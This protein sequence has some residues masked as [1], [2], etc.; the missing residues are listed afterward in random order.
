MIK[1]LTLLFCSLAFITSSTFPE[2]W[3]RSTFPNVWVKVDQDKK[4]EVIRVSCDGSMASMVVKGDTLFRKI[5]QVSTHLIRS[6]ERR[7][8]DHYVIHAYGLVADSVVIYGVSAV[9]YE[10]TV[11]DRERKL[12]RWD[13]IVLEEKDTTTWLMTPAAYSPEFR[14]AKQ[15]CKPKKG[16]FTLGF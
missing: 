12:V 4:G 7:D 1:S 14:K 10:I 16:D 9:D 3:E 8:D 2:R 11:I 6:F 5:P 15:V 13:E